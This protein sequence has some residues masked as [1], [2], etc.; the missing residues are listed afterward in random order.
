[1]WLRGS[2]VKPVDIRAQLR[3]VTD[4][5]DGGYMEGNTVGRMLVGGRSEE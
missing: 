4:N 2:A 5:L 1:M 3:G